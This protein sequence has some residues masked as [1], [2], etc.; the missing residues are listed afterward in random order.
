[1]NRIVVLAGLSAAMALGASQVFGQE[2]ETFDSPN[3]LSQSGGNYQ[4][5]N[6]T[7]TFTAGNGAVITDGPT[8]YEIATHPAAT[9]SG[10][11]SGYHS[12]YSD[13]KPPAGATFTNG[14]VSISGSSMLQLDVTINNGTDAGLF[15]DLQDGEGDFYKYFYGYGLVGGAANNAP[16]QE[17]G[18]TITQGAAPN[19]LILDVPLATPFANINGTSTPLDLSQIT[20]FRIEDDPGASASGAP[21]ASDVSFNDLS[22]VNVPE[23]T[24]LTLGALGCLLVARRRR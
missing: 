6:D 17:P 9:G 3:T 19:E 5:I 23:P 20:L 7:G 1:M 21:N 12:I 8:F 13:D 24:T 16:P 18:E 2:I 22:G 10:Y 11:G 14:V 4:Q 15:V